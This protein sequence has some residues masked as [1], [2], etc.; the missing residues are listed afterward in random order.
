MTNVDVDTLYQDLETRALRYGIRT[1]HVELKPDTPGEFNGPVIRLNRDYDPLERAFYLAHSIGSIAEW[2]LRHAA[3]AAIFAELRQ[4]K[5]N[6]ARNQPGFDRALEEY[7]AFEQR[8]WEFA[9]WNLEDL[10]HSAVVSAFTN[11]GRADLESMRLF[12]ST[13]KAPVWR[14]FFSAWNIEVRRGTR[15]VPPFVAR[16]MPMFRAEAIPQQEIVQEDGD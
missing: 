4:A 11:F 9:V 5:K 14:D 6:R 3:T 2:S 15:I 13:G 10:G 12:H 1:E 16:P 7:L 8:T